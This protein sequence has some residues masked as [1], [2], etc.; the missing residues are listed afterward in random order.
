ME[1]SNTNTVRVNIKISRAIKTWFE[2]KSE[3]TGINQSALM[4]MALSEYIDQKEGM[5]LMD[6]MTAFMSKIDDIEQR[7]GECENRK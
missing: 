4:A 5:K 3:E 7:I 2:N 6:N 1:N